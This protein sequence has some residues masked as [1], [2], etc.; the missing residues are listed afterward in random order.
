MF[1][2]EQLSWVHLSIFPTFV[3]LSRI[4]FKEVTWVWFQFQCLNKRSY[5][6]CG[7]V[8]H[9][10][11]FGNLYPITSWYATNQNNFL[12][13]KSLHSS[14]FLFEAFTWKEETDQ[15][16]EYK[17]YRSNILQTG[18]DCSSRSRCGFSANN[19]QIIFECTTK[20]KHKKTKLYDVC[21][22]ALYES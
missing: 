17:D 7:K 8:L 5:S 18:D 15:R 11:T 1:I 10:I 9:W 6:H 3:S 14:F 13:I 12:K 20:L 22:A 19:N 16:A 2:W 21:Q 4:L